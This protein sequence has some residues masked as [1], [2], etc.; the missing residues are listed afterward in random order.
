MKQA[1]TVSTPDLP[2][3]ESIVTRNE[4]G[5]YLKRNIKNTRSLTD[6]DS[7]EEQNV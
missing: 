4:S 3:T 1:Y 6:V 2:N 7:N 5:R